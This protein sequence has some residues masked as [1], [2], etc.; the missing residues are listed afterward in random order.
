M[1]TGEAIITA[2][3]MAT[4]E[5]EVQSAQTSHNGGIA[6]LLAGW[7]ASSSLVLFLYFPQSWT[8]NRSHGQ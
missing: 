6:A 3:F 5:A 8:V 4:G 7:L 1:A 2:G